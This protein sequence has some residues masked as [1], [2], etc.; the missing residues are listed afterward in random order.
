MGR[1]QH[2]KGPPPRRPPMPRRHCRQA[3]PLAST[4]CPWRPSRHAPDCSKM[5]RQPAAWPTIR[6]QSAVHSRSAD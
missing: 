1:R 5:A 4:G 6:K 2:A 3:P